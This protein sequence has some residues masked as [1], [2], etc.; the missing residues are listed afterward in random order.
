MKT[1]HSNRQKPAARRDP[2]QERTNIP[3]Q[4]PRADDA[5]YQDVYHDDNRRNLFDPELARSLN[6]PPKPPRRRE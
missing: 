2:A 4:N 6:T 3:G 1:R 5:T